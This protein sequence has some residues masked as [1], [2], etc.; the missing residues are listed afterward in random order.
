MLITA[1]I[2]LALLMMSA[3]FSGS[4]TALLLVLKDR[5]LL[6]D[7]L[8]DRGERSAVLRIL[9]EP[10][11]LLMTVLLGNLL[12]NLIFFAL[13]TIF[14]LEVEHHVDVSAGFVVGLLFLFLVIIFGEILPKALAGVVPLKFAR[15]TAWVVLKVM[16]VL[17]PLVTILKSVVEGINRLFGLTRQIDQHISSEHL[18][19]LVGVSGREGLFQGMHGEVLL[20]VMELHQLRLEDICTPR[21]DVHSCSEESTIGEVLGHARHCGISLVPLYKESHDDIVGYIDV[22]RCLGQ[23]KSRRLARTMS[24]PL[25]IFSEL[26]RMDLVLRAFLEKKH[27]LALVVDEYGD[28]SGIVT[29]SDVMSCLKR[30]DSLSVYGDLRELRTVNGR[31]KVK[32]LDFFEGLDVGDAVTL[33]GLLSSRCGHIPVVGE[34]VEIEG[35]QLL[36]SKASTRSV[37]EVV[38]KS[39]KKMNP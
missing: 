35:V 37:K 1:F 10:S 17:W 22:V 34:T 16:Q 24:S 7:E 3:V 28:M 14:V 20:T 4:E 12:V 18:Q 30:R 33:S 31:T 21:V 5:Q 27:P 26:A 2:L 23:E 6:A 38:V 39:L 13:S 15:R 9:A 19:N 29:W 11:R 25:P 36:I 8:R 32:E